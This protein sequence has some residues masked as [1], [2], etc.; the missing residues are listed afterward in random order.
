MLIAVIATTYNRADA[1]S[2]VLEGYL[3]QNDRDFELYVADDGS[4]EETAQMV[5]NYQARADFAIHHIWQE[6]R[7]FRAAAIRNRA[8][9]RAQADYIVF[10]DG[11]CIPVPYFVS[12]HRELAEPGWFV[13]G[14]RVLL[15]EAFTRSVLENILPIHRW[16]LSKWFGA[17]T[18]GD[19]NRVLPLLSIPDLSAVRK[20]AMNRWQGVKTCNLAAWRKDLL[21]VN[22]LD[23]TYSGWGLEDSDL[24]VRLLRAG[25]KHKSARFAAP[26]LHLW[27]GE[28]DRSRFAENKRRLDEVLHSD[29]TR[30]VLGVE[31]YL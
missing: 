11:D 28:N 23:E 24:V 8:L 13:A 30:A 20:L 19:I 6:D 31:Q 5:R 4:T 12:R 29:R 1:L 21:M 10:T 16:N 14:N 27:H 3:A 22:G 17:W 25:I 15:S 26:V 7:G 18:R 9:A 2:A